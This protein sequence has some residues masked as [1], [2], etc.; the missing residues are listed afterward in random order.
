MHDGVVC[1]LNEVRFVPQLK[2]NLISV[3][4][5]EVTGFNVTF[6]SVVAKV[7]KGFLVTSGEHGDDLKDTGTKG[8][9]QGS[10]AQVQDLIVVWRLRRDIRLPAMYMNI[11]VVYALPVESIDEMVPTTYREAEQ[12]SE[13]DLW[14]KAMQEEMKSLHMNNTWELVELPKGRKTIG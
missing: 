4:A 11:V 12:I 13:T 10:T 9:D 8:H 3:R 1:E 6:E 2:K 5:L 7:T 14:Q